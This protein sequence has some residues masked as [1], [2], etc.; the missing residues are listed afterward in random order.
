MESNSRNLLFVSHA[1]P[2]DNV[3][4]RWLSLRLAR[5]GYRVWCDLT[6]LLGG[7]DFWLDIDEAIR[8]QA[9]KLIYVLSRDSNG[10]TGP[11]QELHLGTTVA[12]LNELRD[13][14]IP[15]RVDDIPF[16]DINIQI[17]RLN[18]IDFRKG[19]VEGFRILLD[20]LE[21]DGVAKDPR[22]S[23][24]SV[25]K[26]WQTYGA[27]DIKLMDTQ[28]E[29][30]SNWFA[31]R[32]LPSSLHIHFI[33]SAVSGS[34]TPGPA[35]FPIR[36]F[37]RYVVTFASA[38]DLQDG[39]VIGASI[40]ST[41]TLSTDKFLYGIESPIQVRKQQAHNAVVD[42]LRQGWERLVRSAGMQMFRMGKRNLVAY[43]HDGQTPNNIVQLPTDL[44]LSRYRRVVGYRSLKDGRGNSQRRFWHFGIGVRPMLWPIAGY[45]LI[46]HILFSDD[47][48]AIWDDSNR[49][50]RA[51]R[52][53]SRNWWNPEWRDR[54][55]GIV[56]WLANESGYLEVAMGSKVVIE[57]EALPVSFV[58][59]VSYAEPINILD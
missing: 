8:S 40:L 37:G 7:E 14:V 50:H 21:L 54:T 28:D 13:F 2:E 19:W 12:R 51:R 57:V 36:K 25:A 24:D 29:Y 15:V 1:N 22:Y 31:I 35:P 16:S 55:L 20:K 53:E 11:L 44:G 3:F 56:R 49:R 39:E 33:S 32:E 41:K 52:R 26:W 59:P 34:Q 9:T 43:L 4:S 23:P 58:S 18:A 38:N 30:L 42:L 5:E 17:A 45:G 10:K 27:T 46:P 48:K 6:R 47:G